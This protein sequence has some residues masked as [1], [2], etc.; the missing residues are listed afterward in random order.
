MRL[1]RLVTPSALAVAAACSKGEPKL[2]PPHTPAAGEAVRAK[3]IS[4][5]VTDADSI[6]PPCP[7]RIRY[8]ATL[9]L[10][11]LSG[12]LQYQWVRSTGDKTPVLELDIPGG[13]RNGDADVALQ[14]D[15]WPLTKP[16]TQWSFNEY[17]HVL[18][19][20]DTRTFDVPVEA[21]CYSRK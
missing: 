15:S 3:A 5:G 19:P 8:E 12:K 14:P 21:K 18:S 16:D 2:I 20:I 7:V 9:T 17:I 13:A 1:V 4:G 6:T 10:S 11:H